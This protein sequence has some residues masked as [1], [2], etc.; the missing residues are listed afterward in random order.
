MSEEEPTPERIKKWQNREFAT[1]EFKS[2]PSP[3]APFA[4]VI[5]LLVIYFL[6]KEILK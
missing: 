5:I 6:I 3:I 4:L 1:I 2:V